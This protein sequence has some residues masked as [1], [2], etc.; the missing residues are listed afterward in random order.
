MSLYKGTH[1][2]A[3]SYA[4]SNASDERLVDMVSTLTD[5][6]IDTNTMVSTL[7]DAEVDANDALLSVSMMAS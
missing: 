4:G 2:I 5:I 3:G 6:G 1:L 7:V